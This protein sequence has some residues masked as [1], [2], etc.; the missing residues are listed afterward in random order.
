MSILWSPARTHFSCHTCSLFLLQPTCLYCNH[1]YLALRRRRLP[2]AYTGWILVLQQIYQQ[3]MVQNDALLLRYWR[4]RGICAGWLR[5]SLRVRAFRRLQTPHGRHFAMRR[6]ARRFARRCLLTGTR[7]AFV[8][9][10][11]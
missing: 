8:R 7:R 3:E 6:T 2:F 11:A 5:A 4:A 10:L 1:T 9:M